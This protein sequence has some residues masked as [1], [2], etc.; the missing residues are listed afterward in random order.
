[1]C[2]CNFLTTVLSRDAP[3]TVFAGYP[4]GRIRLTLAGYPVSGLT[5]YPAGQSGIRLD[6]GYEKRPDYPA[7][8]PVHPYYRYLVLYGT[9]TV[10]SEIANKC[11]LLHYKKP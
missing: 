6:T 7:G 5:G 11:L 4:A 2:P 3:D 8:Y 9:G 1:M 10:P